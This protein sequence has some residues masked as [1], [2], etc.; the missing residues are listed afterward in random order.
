MQTTSWGRPWSPSLRRPWSW[1]IEGAETA[2][3][4]TLS[5]SFA[6]GIVAILLPACGINGGGTLTPT[7]APG[8]PSVLTARGGNGSV[9]LDWTET[10]EG[11]QYTVMRSL[12]PAGPF[13]PVSVPSG[14]QKPTRYVDSGLTNG[15][16]YYYQVVA[17][18]SFGQSPAS[19]MAAGTP[20]FKALALAGSNNDFTCL[21]LLRDGTVW[22]WGVAPSTEVLT[23]PTQVAG[24]ADVTAVAAGTTHALALRND[25]TVWAW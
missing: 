24:L 18:N 8:I 3:N 14:F 17:Q 12:L 13:F 9:M 11:S 2:M 6:L 16:T 1:E 23:T 15:T 19:A 25:G 4:R 7:V 22:A 5:R 21:A 20:G 10:A